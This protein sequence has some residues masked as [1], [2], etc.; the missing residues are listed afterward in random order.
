MHWHT[1]YVVHKYDLCPVACS[2]SPNVNCFWKGVLNNGKAGLFNPAFTVAYLG[3]NLPSN[4]SEFT[5]GGKF[6]TSPLNKQ[7]MFHATFG[8]F[9]W[10]EHVFVEAEAAPRNDFLTP[11][12]CQ[13]Y[14]SRGFRWILLWGH[15]FLRSEG[16]FQPCVCHLAHSVTLVTKPGFYAAEK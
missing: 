7:W 6:L 5:R 8:P 11:G 13:A 12:R 15:L 16:K 2:P 3:A 9:R 1:V 10:Q 4:K 14:K